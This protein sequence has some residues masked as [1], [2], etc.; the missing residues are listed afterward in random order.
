M[1]SGAKMPLFC[2]SLKRKTSPVILASAGAL[3]LPAMSFASVSASN[4][5]VSN[6]SVSN[7]TPDRAPLLLADAAPA[8]KMEQ[9]VVDTS[10]PKAPPAASAAPR[11]SPS[12]YFVPPETMTSGAP[13]YPQ[14]QPQS[15]GYGNPP[16]QGGGPAAF[17]NENVI[18]EFGKPLPAVQPT[19]NNTYQGGPGFG[20]GP[21]QSNDEARVGRLE[22]SVLGSMYPEHDI[23]DRVEHLEEELYKTKGSG[24]M[25]ARLRKMEASVFGQSAAFGATNT[26]PPPVSAPPRGGNAPPTVAA[27][28]PSRAPYEMT[29]YPQQPPAS[30]GGGYP[31]G[32]AA[33]QTSVTPSPTNI[34]GTSNGYP[35]GNYGTPGGYSAPGGPP[36][37]GN[38]PY[39]N[40]NAAPQAGYRPPYNAPPRNP[41]QYGAQGQQPPQYPQQ[42]APYPP[43][44]PGG[45]NPNYGAQAPSGYPNPGGMTR[46]GPGGPAYTPQ[47]GVL[48]SGY[49]PQ[50][51]QYPMG[52]APYAPPSGAYGSQGQYPGGGGAG[53][54]TSPPGM[55]LGITVP[56]VFSPDSESQKVLNA[57]HSD[58]GAGDYYSTI[59]KFQT[60]NVARW[61]HFPV[62]IHLPPNTPEL[63]RKNLNDDVKKWSTYVPMKTA[64]DYE[65]FVIEVKWENKLPPGIFGIT[66]VEGSG[67]GLKV[68]I[69][70]LRP[71][72]YPADVP[73]STLQA[74][75]LHEL[76]H[77]IGLYGHSE[78]KEDV[79]FLD[80]KASKKVAPAVNTISQRDLNTL[81][82]IYSTQPISDSFLIQPPLEYNFR[83]G[84]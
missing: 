43:Q 27:Q 15:G 63:W 51:N 28:T 70:L 25:D 44:Q 41:M 7:V 37:Q 19:M 54:G 47:A 52:G 46:T 83:T 11:Q 79:M 38:L 67:A 16:M 55:P 22:K 12:G 66:R 42:S 74:V 13:Q 65:S 39:G 73:E 17:P 69:F 29:P 53:F 80:E 58:P 34:Y 61:Q 5:S 31:P 45:Y 14:G 9:P 32:G 24:P 10:T 3:L 8:L 64:A 33:P 78:N 6:A 40:P 20:T 23:D 18:P 68:I 57:I 77:A 71:T 56:T 48:P 76:G 59:R 81:K 50:A 36:A 4:V 62:L 2:F 21:I 75:F 84:E 30:A 26:A 1:H 82:R 35:P 60:G 49:P 72:F